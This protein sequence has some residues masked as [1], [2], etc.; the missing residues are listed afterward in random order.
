MIN[1][2]L[3]SDFFVV[4]ILSTVTLGLKQ[5]ARNMSVIGSIC[6]CI[7]TVKLTRPEMK[8]GS[9]RHRSC[10]NIICTTCLTLCFN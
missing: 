6:T 4:V 7:I 5:I 1:N 3:T 2:I 10:I 9:F 8:T